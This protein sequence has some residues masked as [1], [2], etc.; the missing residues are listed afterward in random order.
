MTIALANAAAAYANAAKATGP[1]LASRDSGGGFG[2][3]LKEAAESAIGT[4]KEGEAVSA[5]AITGKAD[6]SDVVTAVS[7]AELTLQTV[8][9]V[10]DRVI[11]AYQDIIRMPI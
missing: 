8:T 11:A 10:R 2:E 9:A 4:L 6:I 1:G 7:N 3:L 5:Q